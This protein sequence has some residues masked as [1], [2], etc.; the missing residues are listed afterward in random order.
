M[1]KTFHKELKTASSGKYYDYQQDG[2]E[3]LCTNNFKAVDSFV[4]TSNCQ[5][6]KTSF[7]FIG[8]TPSTTAVSSSKSNFSTN[9]FSTMSQCSNSDIQ[10]SLSTIV[11]LTYLKHV[12][13]KFLT[14]R[15]YQV[16]F[17]IHFKF[18]IPKQVF[19][20]N[21]NLQYQTP[22]WYQTNAA[23]KLKILKTKK[24]T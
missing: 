19:I 6:R 16:I 21:K 4:S 18:W 3:S 5:D 7:E 24:Y 22:I 17:V 10:D 12:I 13:F 15:E 2:D 11:D 23:G 8:P 1:K 14:S 20:K 9:N